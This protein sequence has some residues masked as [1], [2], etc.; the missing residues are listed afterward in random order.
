M[1]AQKKDGLLRGHMCSHRL[2]SRACITFFYPPKKTLNN[3]GMRFYLIYFTLIDLS[4]F[5]TDDYT[6]NLTSSNNFT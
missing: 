2:Y 3:D 6:I 1:V 4:I 5:Q